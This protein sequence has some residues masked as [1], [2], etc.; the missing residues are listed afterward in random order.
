[1]NII[2]WLTSNVDAGDAMIGGIIALVVWFILWKLLIS[3]L[4]EKHK[5]YD[6]L[7]LGA[8]GSF[9]I[10]LFLSIIIVLFVATFQAVGSFGLQLLFPVLLFWGGLIVAVIFFIKKFKK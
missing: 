6:F 8:I 1:M 9:S 3:K 10:L 7:E 4:F 2:E 5:L